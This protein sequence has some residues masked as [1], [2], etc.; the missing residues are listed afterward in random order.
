M[1]QLT[2]AQKESI[3]FYREKWR[4]IIFYTAPR[5]RGK[6]RE[7]I[8]N[9]YELVEFP[10]PKILFFDSPYGLAKDLN[11][12]LENYK[13]NSSEFKSKIVK[14]INS[15]KR[16]IYSIKSEEIIGLDIQLH[17]YDSKL[18]NLVREIW[19]VLYQEIKDKF[20]KEIEPLNYDP[21]IKIFDDALN[22]DSLLSYCAW[23]DFCFS[24][25]NIEDN[26]FKQFT[27]EIHKHCGTVFAFREVCLICDRPKKLLFDNKGNLHAEATPAIEYNDGFSAYADRGVWLPEKYRKLPY[28]DWQTN[29]LLNEPNRKLKQTLIKGIGSKKIYRELTDEQ[30]EQLQKYTFYDIPSDTNIELK[31]FI[32]KVPPEKQTLTT[33]YREKWREIIFSTE[34]IDRKKAAETVKTIYKILGEAEPEIIF[35][36]SPSEKYQILAKNSDWSQNKWVTSKGKYIPSH[37]HDRL[38]ES[39]IEKLYKFC[40]APN[41]IDEQVEGKNRAQSH[42]I[43]S[44]TRDLID[45]KYNLF[46]DYLWMNRNH[47]DPYLSF[48][49]FCISELKYKIDPLG[50]AYLELR[51]NCEDIFGLPKVCLI[52]DRPR[53]LSFNSQNQLHSEGSPAI[54]Y[55]DGF[56]I[57]AYRGVLLPEKYGT[58]HPTKWQSEWLLSETNAELK[59]ALIQGIGY[60]KICQ[61][62]QAV[63]INTWRE[64]ELLRIDS[65]IDSEAVYLL[66]MTCPSTDKI[67]ALRVPPNLN[68]AREAIKWVNWG[69]DPEEFEI[70]T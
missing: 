57:Y 24:E 56:S 61:E 31:A 5:N 38:D 34:P 40:N 58:I 18:D 68:S 65:N 8:E 37:W 17:I 69:I 53:K 63:V 62:L 43:Y 64:Y 30:I 1:I 10:K 12:N 14:E 50:K 70:E 47:Y 46:Q 52:G 32:N 27:V 23:Y 67:H 3:T 26:F 19:E 21:Y 60:D 15:V 42:A 6:A 25:L 11:Q 4:N 66:Q 54:E 49:D 28:K 48:T 2:E 59:R 44:K 45:R 39:L 13:K 7:V 41:Q 20:L 22:H 9:F 29:W 55:R 36:S 33:I 51:E 16:R 35:H